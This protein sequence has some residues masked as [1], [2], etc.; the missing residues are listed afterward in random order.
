MINK[1]IK[2]GKPVALIRG[3]GNTLCSTGHKNAY[4]QAFF[5][6]QGASCKESTWKYTDK[7]TKKGEH[8]CCGSKVAWRHKVDCPKNEGDVIYHLIFNYEPKGPENPKASPQGL[9]SRADSPQDRLWGRSY[10]WG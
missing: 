6:G 1:K 9:D 8:S 4:G 7:K 3:Y 2:K 5:D 10:G